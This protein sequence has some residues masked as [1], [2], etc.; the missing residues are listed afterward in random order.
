[1]NNVEFYSRFSD[2]IIIIVK[3]TDVNELKTILQDRITIKEI[4]S[5]EIELSLIN[6]PKYNSLI[7]NKKV[8]IFNSDVSNKFDFINSE[9]SD[10]INSIHFNTLDFRDFLSKNNQL[11][12]FDVFKEL[13]QFNKREP[14]SNSINNKEIYSLMYKIINFITNS[15]INFYI[16]RLESIM[17]F[18]EKYL[19]EHTCNILNIIKKEVHQ[20]KLILV[21]EKKLNYVKNTEEYLEK[22]QLFFDIHLNIC[23]KSAE[24]MKNKSGKYFKSFAIKSS[25]LSNPLSDR[26]IDINNIFRKLEYYPHDIHLHHLYFINIFDFENTQ[27]E[28]IKLSYIKLL[29]LYAKLNGYKE[30]DMTGKIT[31]CSNDINLINM[32]LDTIKYKKDDKITLGL[33]NVNVKV[34]ELFSNRDNSQNNGTLTNIKNLIE[35][36]SNYKLDFLIMPELYI[37]YYELEQYANFSWEKGVSIISGCKYLIASSKIQNFLVNFVSFDYGGRK[38]ILPIL[39]LKNQYAPVE[40]DSLLEKNKKL[41]EGNDLYYVIKLNNI[42]Y[43]TLYCYEATDILVRASLKDKIDTLFISEF[44]KDT[45]YF[46]NIIESITRDL[47]C[48]VVQS[49]VSQYGDSRIIQPTSSAEMDLIS[50]KGGI[51]NVLLIGEINPTRMNDYKNHYNFSQF[52][53][54]CSEITEEEKMLLYNHI[55][56]V[57]E[58]KYNFKKLSSNINFNPTHKLNEYLNIINVILEKN[59]DNEMEKNI[60]KIKKII[61]S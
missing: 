13:N 28:N 43:S 47:S 3:S 4:S 19:S 1:M 53:L 16:Y 7:F 33:S 55:K 40:Y 59:K 36:N 20:F 38:S 57:M 60:L 37:D 29:N 12:N 14:K 56:T 11:D 31:S 50:V 46:S 48:Y 32:S 44:N 30:I 51:N 49:N 54:H 6:M 41:E 9:Y 58:N 42:K 25:F 61:S 24:D 45:K 26:N 2:D 8:K 17:I 18:M 35:G 27:V 15:N 52:I 5:S 39:R 22:I 21:T 10:F 23:H 34:E